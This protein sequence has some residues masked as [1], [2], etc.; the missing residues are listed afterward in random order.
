MFAYVVR[1]LIAAIP[2]LVVASFL[3]YALVALSGDPLEPMK[4]RNPPAPQRTIDLETQ[5]L[6]LDDN[7]F[8]RY[9]HW[10]WGV[11]HGNFGES[12]QSNYDIGDNLARSSVVTLRLVVVAM[13][14]ALILAVLTGVLSAVRQYSKFDYT[15]TFLGF[16]FL[17]MPS[18]WIAIVLKDFAVRYNK[19][20]GTTVFYTIGETSQNYDSLSAAGKFGDIVG[21]LVLPTISLALISY[22]A[23]SRYQRAAMLEV[24]NS[25]Y[26]RLARAKG[27]TWRKVLVKHVLRTALIPLVTVT[28]L[29][30]AAILG[31][32]VITETVFNW[33]GLGRMLL[34]GVSR[35]DTNAVAGWLLLAGLVVIAFNVIADVLY[36][37][38]DPRIRHD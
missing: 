36:A 25:D 14:L 38:L 2:V 34:T 27:L 12:V 23:W 33:N 8:A 6:G 11:L 19:A 29:D 7:I 24:L 20:T 32:A 16:V 10:L 22:A 18:F 15:T 35:A 4:L 17:A 3:A 1:R 37:V 21:H 26:V 5:R 9:G 28:A 31:G 30:I 13:L